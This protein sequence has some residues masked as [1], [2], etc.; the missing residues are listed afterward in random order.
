MFA[1]PGPSI[2][3]GSGQLSVTAE[4]SH[5]HSGQSK[6]RDPAGHRH[7]DRKNA[8][9]CRGPISRGRS[10]RYPYSKAV[11]AAFS[12][13]WSSHLVFCLLLS[14]F[15]SW[16]SSCTVSKVHLWRKKVFKNVSLP[17]ASQCVFQPARL[18]TASVFCPVNIQWFQQKMDIFVCFEQVL[19]GWLL[20]PQ[21][22]H[23]RW[24]P[25]GFRG[26][27]RRPHRKMPGMDKEHKKD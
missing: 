20:W 27:L 8:W 18:K 1:P 15:R 13:E 22:P 4:H 19:Y 9:R 5:H 17:F 24:S 6:D 3:R 7:P 26:P 12:I 25:S 14:S 2:Q 11:A 10:W 21:P 23:R 16:T